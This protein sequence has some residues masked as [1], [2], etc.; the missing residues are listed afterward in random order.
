MASG[1]TLGLIEIVC[2]ILD[3]NDH[4]FVPN[5]IICTKTEGT[6]NCRIQFCTKAQ[7]GID[8]DAYGTLFLKYKG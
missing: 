1:T 6:I 5:F 2:L 4:T 8:W 3:I 7:M